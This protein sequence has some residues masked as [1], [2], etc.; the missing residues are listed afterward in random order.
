MDD[1]HFLALSKAKADNYALIYKSKEIK[2]ETRKR[3]DGVITRV[4]VFKQQ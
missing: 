3:V 4:L 2:E 1:A